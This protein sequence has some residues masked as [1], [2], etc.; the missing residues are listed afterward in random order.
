MP[1]DTLGSKVSIGRQAE[2][3]PLSSFATRWIW[4]VD[5]AQLVPSDFDDVA[6]S[7]ACVQQ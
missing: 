4:V 1:L 2:L 7:L 6:H 3:S 5:G